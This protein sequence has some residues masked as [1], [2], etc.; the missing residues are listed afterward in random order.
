MLETIKEKNYKILEEL[1]TFYQQQKDTER[2]IKV[3][4]EAH[5]LNERT[6]GEAS[7]ACRVLTTITRTTHPVSP[8]SNSRQVTLTRV[9]R[10]EMVLVVGI[11]L[12]EFAF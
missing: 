1:R 7:T 8:T 11:M 6:E 9:Q 10:T 3:G 4:H 5:K 12:K 2:Q